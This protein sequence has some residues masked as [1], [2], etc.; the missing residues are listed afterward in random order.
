M[1]NILIILFSIISIQAQLKLASTNVH[2]RLNGEQQNYYV[3]PTGILTYS[4]NSKKLKL[5]IHT[6]D[7]VLPQ[8]KYEVA[9]VYFDST[10]LEKMPNLILS[11][12]IDSTSLHHI[13]IGNTTR[14][15]IYSGLIYYKGTE[16]NVT[17]YISR[18]ENPS[19]NNYSSIC[20]K[21][22]RKDIDPPLTM[23]KA[24]G[25]VDNIVIQTTD[26][27]LNYLD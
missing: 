18:S 14:D 13:L 16:V 8:Q 19:I 5:T 20:I 24:N 26:S 9:P 22:D 12:S 17:V 11:V 7:F 25:L 4:N 27:W 15:H 3:E 2:V 1:K 21:V 6:N 10:Y 23:D